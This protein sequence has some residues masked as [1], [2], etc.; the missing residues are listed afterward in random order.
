M[1][2]STNSRTKA[3]EA[4]KGT[5][6]TSDTELQ[7]IFAPGLA[8][9]LMSAD[10]AS[11]DRILKNEITA[12]FAALPPYMHTM[13]EKGLRNATPREL[14]LA[15]ELAQFRMPLADGSAPVVGLPYDWYGEKQDGAGDRSPLFIVQRIAFSGILLKA[16]RHTGDSRFA[17]VLRDYIIDYTS[18]YWTAST[19]LSPRDN[20]LCTS[21]RCGLWFDAR[22]AG[23]HAALKEL[24]R[25]P[26]FSFADLVTI[27]IAM[28]HM[29]NGLL[30]NLALGSNWRV[31]ELAGLFTQGVSSPFLKHSRLWRDTA[32]NSL[33]EEFE[34]Q[35]H[36]D[37]SHE[38]L[39]IGYGSG[40]WNAFA[41][42]FV[43]SK[44]APRWG[45]AFDEKRIGQI[46]DYFL[47]SVKPFGL[48][49]AMGDVY[50]IRNED[51]LAR[52]SKP[53]TRQP[54][55]PRS[56][57]WP[58]SV[59]NS[60]RAI[61]RCSAFPSTRFILSGRPAPSWTSR[62]N[63]SSGYMFMRDGWQP[64][65]LYMSLNMGYHANCHCHYSLLGIEAA[66][67]G[68]EFIVDPG[69]SE[70]GALP[71][72]YNFRRTRGHSTMTVDGLD[73]QT[74]SPVQVSRLF[75]GDRYDFA[76]GVYRGGYVEGNPFRDWKNAFAAQ[77]FRHVL[78]VKGGYWIVFDAMIAPAG[79]TA[80]T[81]FQFM[82]TRMRA[83]KTG[84]YATGWNEANLALLPLQ[85]DGWKHEVL[86]GQMNPIEGWMPSPKREFVPSPV[87]KA[88]R[89]TEP[90]PLWHGSLLFPYR[91]STM[92][93]MEVTN[94]DTGSAGF[95][96]RI[97]TKEY[98]DLLFLSNSWMP[99]P[100][101]LEG[102][103]TDAACVHARFAGG[104]IESLFACEGNYLSLAGS[105]VFRAPGTMLAREYGFGRSRTLS[106]QNP[107]YKNR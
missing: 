65:D 79:R 72:D 37:G 100:V 93:A 106:V 44:E 33:N 95:G 80:E 85:W 15:K 68:R 18:R 76:V 73:Q 61:R 24:H 55:R 28:T 3:H 105:D 8:L 62:F 52:N 35:F 77:H 87:Y 107:R 2:R 17:Q 56:E 40:V 43:V 13:V 48:S 6:P 92:P 16:Y 31:Y 64:D 67:Y 14:K 53:A 34:I 54:R 7:R 30:P 38:E 97:C 12:A 104:K 103:E 89:R 39:S 94:L 74:V 23:I 60:A 78:F 82:P 26:V 59:Y 86:E 90:S 19:Q 25:L 91:Q 22:W 10:T 101:R 20:W 81:R 4:P 102:I 41:H 50:A 83:L 88:T 96:Y 29:L 84:G 1:S 9:R 71:I 36:A 21:V 47:S 32:V 46:Q 98:T 58:D 99:A 66:G 45:L 75:M 27:Y 69:N 11:R 63:R 51:M 70:L 42:F 5:P 49:S 57:I